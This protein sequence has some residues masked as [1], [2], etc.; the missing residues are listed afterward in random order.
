MDNPVFLHTLYNKTI[1]L[2]YQTELCDEEGMS[3]NEWIKSY[4]YER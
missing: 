1:P 3:D 2:M 4:N